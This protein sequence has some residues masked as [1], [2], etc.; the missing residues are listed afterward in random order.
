MSQMTS[1][2]IIG[3]VNLHLIKEKKFKTNLI[4][5]Y[6]QRPLSA[7][8]VTYNA[9]IPMILQRGTS[10]YKTAKALSK[11]LE[12]LYGALLNGIVFKKGEKQIIEFNLGIPDLR[13][14][15]DKKLLRQAIM[16]LNGVINQP[17]L[18]NGGFKRQYIEQE[19]NNLINRMQSRVNDKNKYALER[20]IEE[21]C[22]EENFR[23][24]ELGNL[25]DL[26]DIDGVQLYQ[27]YGRI[28][29][30]SPIDIVAVG[31]QAFDQ[32]ADLFREELALKGGEVINIPRETIVYH[33]AK[34]KKIHEVMEVSQGKLTIGYRTN[35]PFE[36]DEYTDLMV[37][38][39]LL[40]GG[41]HAKL[42]MKVREERSLCYYIYARLEKF[43]SIMLISCGIEKEKYEETLSVIEEQL[44]AVKNGE[45]TDQ[46]F[47]STKKAMINSIK[48]MGD[49][50]NTLAD[51]YYSQIVGNRIVT[52]EEMIKRIEAVTKE[53]LM[54]VARKIEKDT[55]Y[56]LSNGDQK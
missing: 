28:L 29:N 10:H 6:F 49:N 39:N 46:E 34:V 3:N 19:V 4:K 37:Y 7:Q 44:E 30:N 26:K 41:A 38:S 25:E 20:C 45:I 18:E 8:E 12:D 31:D 2:R 16:L 24:H 33:P 47:I 21:M 43:K 15:D 50:Q 42:F 22:S 55:I 56:F 27:Q 54:A 52:P 14:I 48:S 13:Y 35:I 40:G 9:L 23:L 53:S 1:E 36:A 17:V 11:K 32:L 51:Y 5:V